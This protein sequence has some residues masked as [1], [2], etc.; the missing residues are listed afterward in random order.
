MLEQQVLPEDLEDQADPRGV[1]HAA[2]RYSNDPAN[3]TPASNRTLCT[4]ALVALVLAQAE[5]PGG[6]FFDNSFLRFLD[7]NSCLQATEAPETLGG[8]FS[9]KGSLHT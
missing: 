7:H 8:E 2:Y 3:R 9:V 1:D 4:P 6:R 5:D